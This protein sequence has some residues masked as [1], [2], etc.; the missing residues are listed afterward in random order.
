MLKDIES[1][2]SM[3]DP[4]TFKSTLMDNGELM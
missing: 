1:L 4:A 3:K 2:S